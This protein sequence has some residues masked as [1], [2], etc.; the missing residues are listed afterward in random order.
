MV[1]VVFL[2]YM[3]GQSLRGEIDIE[4]ILFKNVKFKR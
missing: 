3:D 2:G 1:I 4:N